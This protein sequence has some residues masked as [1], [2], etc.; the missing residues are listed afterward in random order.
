MRSFFTISVM[1]GGL[2]AAM[3]ANAQIVVPL[4]GFGFPALQTSIGPDGT[5]Y[6]LGPAAGST[7]Q[8][9]STEVTAISTT[10][11]TAP[12]WTATI[13]GRVSQLLPGATTVFVVQSSTSGMGRNTTLTTSVTLLSAA[14]GV[15][16]T[17]AP[18]SL[19]G[20]ISGIEVRTVGTTDYL[21][22]TLVATSSITNGGSTTFTSATTLTIYSAT[23]AVIKTVTL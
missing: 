1:I 5:F 9:P 7:N 8:N 13:T 21:Y 12:K 22:V 2:M 16:E 11:G 14:T 17:A 4:P 6:A 23:G 19:T 10:T 20:N 15:A 3:Q 18:I